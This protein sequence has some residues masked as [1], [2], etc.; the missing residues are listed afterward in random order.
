LQ[1]TSGQCCEQIK[2]REKN[3]AILSGGQT[4]WIVVK[5]DRNGPDFS[6]AWNMNVATKALER[7]AIAHKVRVEGGAFTTTD[8]SSGERKR[9]ALVHA[10][11]EKRPIMM[12]DEWPADQDPTFRRAFYTE[13]L[14]ELKRLGKTLIVVS[15]DDRYFD[16]A[17]RIVRMANGNIV[18]D[19]EST[20][21]ARCRHARL[22]RLTRKRD[23]SWSGTQLS[24]APTD[25]LIER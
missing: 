20:P 15:H 1:Q 24:V 19:A 18:P 4:Y 6:D 21:E 8:L 3:G 23:G 10:L 13:L 16:V 12:F 5:A 17:D 9:L 11:V 7:F 25:L 22:T 14:P 2:L